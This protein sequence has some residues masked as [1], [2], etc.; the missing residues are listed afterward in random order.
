[1]RR[2]LFALIL[3]LFALPV[4]AQDRSLVWE[5]WDVVIDN[6]DTADNTFDVTEI[7]DI[8]FSGTFRFGSAVIPMNNLDAISDVEVSQDGRSLTRECTDRPGTYCARV[9]EEGL[10]IV[11]FF[12]RPITSDSANFEIKYTVEGALRSYEGGDQLWWIAIPSDHFGFP[13]ESSTITVEMPQGF[14]PRE[15]VDRVDTYGAAG[16]VEVRGTRIMATATER[17]TD[18][19]T[20]EIRVQYPHD[21]RMVVP[22]W[23]SGFDQQRAFMESTGAILP[24]LMIGLG[25]LLLLGGPLLVYYMWYSRGR[26]PKIGPV[27]TYLTEPPSDLRPAVVGTLIDEQANVHDILSTLMDLAH[28]EYV[29]IEE[30]KTEGFFGLGGGSEFTFKR[31]DQD[32]NQLSSFERAFINGFFG[33]SNMEQTLNALKNRFYVHIP[34]LENHLYDEVVKAGL[35]TNNPNSTRAA[36]SGIGTFVLI[37]AGV[38]GFVAFNFAESFGSAGF[39]LLCAPMAIGL[40]GILMMIAGQHM[41]AKTRAGAEEAAKWKA[42]MEYLKNLEK[43]GKLEEAAGTFEKYLPYAVAFGLERTWMRKFERVQEYIPPPVWY[44]PT[45]RGGRYSR[46]YTAGTPLPRYDAP[47]AGDFMPGELA[48]AGG[49]GGFNEM[50][51]DLSGAFESI[52]SGLTT[53]L[54]SAGNVLTSRPQSSSSGSWS[55]GGGGWSGGGF[56]GGGGSGGGSRGFG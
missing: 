34:Q 19:Q 45:Y 41:P 56:S 13:I 49:E 18:D 30:Q 48:R 23:Q 17:I 54:N 35:F 33:S 25:L 21:P 7:Y 51:D 50:A 43:Y 16:E 4:A 3:F 2:S 38:L 29:V 52:S 14:G 11:Y 55:S 12:R 5:R 15:G 1:M 40:T 9:V 10:S 26:D 32:L 47:N 20:F 6:V 28:R 8:D 46:G 31:T 39:S 42:F 36:W 44:Y 27:P 53:M 22:E 24:P 37:I